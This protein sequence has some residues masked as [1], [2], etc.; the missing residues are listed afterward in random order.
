ME[1]Q[2]KNQSD[3]VNASVAGYKKFVRVIVGIFN[4]PSAFTCKSE[5]MVKERLVLAY[6]TFVQEYGFGTSDIEAR[7]MRGGLKGLISGSSPDDYLIS[8]KGGPILEIWIGYAD[9]YRT[10]EHYKRVQI[11][12]DCKHIEKARILGALI[13]AEGIKVNLLTADEMKVLVKEYMAKVKEFDSH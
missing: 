3:K 5:V 12:V 11:T 2:K 10:N 1:N 9:N 7:G 8:G 4:H 6:S 13:E